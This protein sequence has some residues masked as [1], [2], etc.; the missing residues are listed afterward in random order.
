MVSVHYTGKLTADG[1]IFDK[2]LFDDGQVDRTMQ[3]TRKDDDGADLKGWDRGYPFEFRL[4][5]GDVI[6]GWDEGVE[7]MRVG[8]RRE[9]EVPPWLA[10]G[11]S[12]AGDSIPPNATLTF[13]VE[14]L[15]VREPPSLWER[16][17]Y[18]AL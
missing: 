5:A 8:E 9:L 12:G 3:G 1:T 2:S 4:G 13:E 11:E 14:L 17:T 6:P 10:Y 15:E 7:G 16:W 18:R